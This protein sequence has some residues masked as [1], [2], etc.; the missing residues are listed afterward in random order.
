MRGMR[1]LDRKVLVLAMAIVTVLGVFAGSLATWGVAPLAFSGAGGAGPV[2]VGPYPLYLT[3]AFNPGSGHDEYFP[4]NFTVPAHVL[5]VVTITNYDNATNP[6]PSADGVVTGTLGDTETILNVS[7]PN[8]LVESTVN[9]TDISHTFT[10]ATGG[11]QLNIPVP[12][13]ASLSVPTTVTFETYF[14]IT[15]SFV[16]HCLAP[17]DM[18][19]MMTP[20]Y[21]MGTMTVES[22]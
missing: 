11:Y 21:M 17:C 13:A 14:N 4:A 10:V 12:P 1:P 2:S 5:V 15:G 8:G 18:W 16:W 6:V 9:G 20:G 19:S 3:V 7:F 22:T